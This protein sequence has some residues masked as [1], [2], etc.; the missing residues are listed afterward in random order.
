MLS[1]NKGLFYK[2]ADRYSVK[3]RCWVS[4]ENWV[5]GLWILVERINCVKMHLFERKN[6]LDWKMSMRNS[7]NQEE[8]KIKLRFFRKLLSFSFVK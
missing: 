8:V 2:R 5:S 4:F 7:I 6:I 1:H 3:Q